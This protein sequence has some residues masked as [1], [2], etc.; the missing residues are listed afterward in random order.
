MAI[1]ISRTRNDIKYLT[2]IFVGVYCAATWIYSDKLGISNDYLYTHHTAMA[3]M[4][5]LWISER[6]TVERGVFGHLSIIAI[7]AL[8]AVLSNEPD[9]FNK[10]LVGLVVG[11]CVI[12]NIVYFANKALSAYIHRE[13]YAITWTFSVI[14]IFLITGA[15]KPAHYIVLVPIV[16]L[17]FSIFTLMLRSFRL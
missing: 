13:A 1:E 11:I 6:L 5:Y 9:L 16:T 15:Y 2:L 7:M 4:L 3:W 8:T 12:I 17:T 14:A 10:G